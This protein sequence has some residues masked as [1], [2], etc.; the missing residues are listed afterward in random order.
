MKRPPLSG[1][2][3]KL[4]NP[5]KVFLVIIFNNFQKRPEYEYSQTDATSVAN[6]AGDSSELPKEASEGPFRFDEISA[7]IR[8]SL[9]SVDDER[10]WRT[11]ETGMVA[12]SLWCGARRFWQEVK[13]RALSR[14]VTA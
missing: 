14:S 12:K 4:M 13:P 3:F 1:H 10:P 2:L 9:G 7:A 5:L 8:T 11:A 6:F